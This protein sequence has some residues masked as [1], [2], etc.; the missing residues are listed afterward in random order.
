L[1]RDLPKVLHGE[2]ELWWHS[3]QLSH[4]SVPS[5]SDG[6]AFSFGAAPRESAHRGSGR[7]RSSIPPR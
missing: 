7:R 5:S 2:D 3:R 4:E 1:R 6:R